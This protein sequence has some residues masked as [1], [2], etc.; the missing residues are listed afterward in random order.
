MKAGQQAKRAAELLNAAD[1][2]DEEALRQM[3]ATKQEIDA[4]KAWRDSPPPK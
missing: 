4:A 1:A 2:G 3:G